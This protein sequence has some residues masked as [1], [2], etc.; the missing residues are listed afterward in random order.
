MIDFCSQNWPRDPIFGFKTM[1]NMV[2]VIELETN[3]VDKL[4]KN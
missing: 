2:K 4:E 3:L 1:K